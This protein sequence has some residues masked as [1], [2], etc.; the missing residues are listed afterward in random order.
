MSTSTDATKTKDDSLREAMQSFFGSGGANGV[1][2]PPPSQAAPT[3][4]AKPASPEP[5]P[6]PTPAAATPAPAKKPRPTATPRKPSAP[7]TATTPTGPT[8]DDV[9]RVASEAADDVPELELSD[10]D[11][12]MLVTLEAMGSLDPKRYGDLAERTKKFWAEEQKYKDKWEKEHPGQNYDQ[13]ADEHQEFYSR[14]EPQYD[15]RTFK[16]AEKRVIERDIEAKQNARKQRERELAEEKA[17]QEKESTEISTAADSTILEIIS[18]VVPDV[19]KFFKS[20]DEAVAITKESWEKL[21]EEDPAAAK[22]IRRP[23]EFLGKQLVEFERLMRYPDT[24]QFNPDN[25]IHVELSRILLRKEAQIK[26]LKP[27]D[28]VH[29]GRVFATQEEWNEMVNNLRV[30]K[31]MSRDEK[32]QAFDALTRRYWTITPDYHRDLVVASARRKVK[33]KLSDYREVE[34]ATKKKVKPAVTPAP[35]PTPTAAA[36]AAAPAPTPAPKPTPAH[37]PPTIATSSDRM[38]AASGGG[39]APSK[40]QE[41]VDRAFFS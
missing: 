31:G 4:V 9:A 41:V 24:Y 3:P 8:L 10:I 6:K 19:A 40:T 35:Q 7:P 14:H 23:L 1:V 11:R 27:E 25:D 33:D 17:R 39:G 18:M 29:E 2:D 32:K 16:V 15:E 34:E 30:N 38:P 26:T 28:Q 36:P 22:A 5:D 20:E 37:K 13:E 12:D 21:A